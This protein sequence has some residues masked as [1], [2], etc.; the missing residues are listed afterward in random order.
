MTTT[1]DDDLFAHPG[2]PRDPEEGVKRDRYGRYLLPHPGSGREMAWTRATTF[3]KTISDTY[4]LNMW[5]RRMTA[6]GLTMREDLYAL[7][8]ATDLDDRQTL[9]DICE[10]AAEAAGAKSAAALGTAL[11]GFTE[12]RD[13]GEKVT[14]PAKWRPDVD[15]YVKALDEHGIEVEPEMIERIVIVRKYNVAGTFDRIFRVVKRC[16]VVLPGLDPFDL[17]PGSLIMG[18]LK[19]GRTLEYGWGEIVVQLWLYANADLIWNKKTDRYEEMPDVDKRVAVVAHLPVG[20]HQC[21]MFNLNLGL[22]AHAAELCSQVRAWRTTKGFAVPRLVTHAEPVPEQNGSAA[23]VV[24]TEDPAGWGVKLD[25]ARTI[26]DLSR[27]WREATA[28]RQW[29][30]DLE[31]RGMR[32]R[33]QILADTAGERSE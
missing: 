8:A 1:T 7:A 5:G 10:R 24:E 9:N 13:R 23:P 3:A 14:V 18:D 16:R 2:M 33:A 20:Q 19:T 22:A 21:T 17:E 6:K 25:T 27:I 30:P 4:T 11:H 28:A 15:A 26:D 29:S 12:Q 31:Q 32:R